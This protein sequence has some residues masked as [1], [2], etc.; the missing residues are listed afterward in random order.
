MRSRSSKAPPAFWSAIGVFNACMRAHLTLAICIAQLARCSIA[1]SLRIRTNHHPM[2]LAHS[3]A[4][5]A[6]FL[7]PRLGNETTINAHAFV[8]RASTTQRHLSRPTAAGN[9]RMQRS[10]SKRGKGV[11]SSGLKKG[12]EV[13][14][15]SGATRVLKLKG[16]KGTRDATEEQAFNDA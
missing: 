12:D 4:S 6:R 16:T 2:I 1:P 11:D 9:H 14:W 5:C 7:L 8:M 15:V 3:P 10:D 13:A